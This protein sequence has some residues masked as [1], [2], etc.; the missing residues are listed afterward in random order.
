MQ[1]QGLIS[2]IF[3]FIGNVEELIEFASF[4]IW[5][6]YGLAVVCL[7]VL[8]KTQ[9]DLYRPYKVPLCIPILTIGI[10]IFLTLTPIFASENPTKY[11]A[12]LGFIASGLIFYVPFVFYKYRPNLMGKLRIMQ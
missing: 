9:P 1:F 5:I 10:A 7:F 11:L 4:L 2:L 3:I 12:A 6:F 8:R